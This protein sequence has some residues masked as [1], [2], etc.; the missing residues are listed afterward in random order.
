MQKLS[1]EKFSV[2]KQGII[3]GMFVILTL[4]FLAETFCCRR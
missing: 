4:K 1:K 2:S 3:T